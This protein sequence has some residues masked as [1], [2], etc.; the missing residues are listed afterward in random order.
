MANA[1]DKTAKK[2]IKEIH[3]HAHRGNIRIWFEG[4]WLHVYGFTYHTKFTVKMTSKQI[5]LKVDP[6][7]DRFVSG[8]KRKGQD[9][10]TALIDLSSVAVTEWIAQKEVVTATFTAGKIVIKE[11]KIVINE[12][13]VS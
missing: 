6:E 13:K 8:R 5:V 7:G 3:K 10:H 2:L 4:K 9:Q 12:G 11:G 1:K